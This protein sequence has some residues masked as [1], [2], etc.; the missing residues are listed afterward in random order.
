[1]GRKTKGWSLGKRDPRTGN[2]QVF[3][4]H[5]GRQL[6]RSTRTSD[7]RQAQLEAERIYTET[8]SGRRTEV[9]TN[10]SLKLLF[11]EWLVDFE[12]EGAPVTTGYY[13]DLV[14]RT[15]LPFF[16]TF[17]AVTT[18]GADDYRRHRLRQV[19]RSTVVRELTALRTFV[20]WAARKQ[21]LA[22]PVDVKDPGRSVIGTRVLE[23]ELVEM[24]AREVEAILDNLPAR[25]PFGNHP[26]ALMTTIWESSLRIG[27]MQ[28]LATPK[29]YRR[30][31][32]ILQ[33]VE[34][35]DKGRYAR[36]I[37]L[38]PRAR[39]LLDDACAD[40]ERRTGLIFG[41]YDV[42]RALR[43]AAKKAGFDGERRKHLSP[44]DFRH[45]AITHAQEVSQNIAGAA[46]MAGH[47]R[48]ATT[49]NYTHPR[50]T[51]GLAILEARFG[52]TTPRTTPRDETKGPRNA[53][54]LGRHG[55]FRTADPYRVKVVLS[56]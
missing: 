24:S 35:T 2:Y 3:F 23:T 39:A 20:S 15:F 12:A 10:K 50:Y 5:N 44:H 28:R 16:K 4:T 46:Y 32:S 43:T 14:A 37:P 33:V 49:A 51:H 30:G 1:M 17:D 52:D 38:T 36:K 40:A 41:Q 56:H 55:R 34:V 47:K 45:A 6:H 21:Y 7:A 31:S 8:I 19:G 22:E 9:G 26:K 13:T 42:R 27:T 29:H 53:F 25:T 48:T 18:C 54:S 11:A